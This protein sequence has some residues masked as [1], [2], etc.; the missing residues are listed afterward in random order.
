MKYLP[1]FQSKRSRNKKSVLIYNYVIDGN[2][3][4]F[5]KT[6]EGRISKV[7]VKLK[8]KS[9]LLNDI[10]SG[11]EPVKFEVKTLFSKTVINTLIGN[12]K[13]IY[14]YCLQ[15]AKDIEEFCNNIK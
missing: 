2:P 5:E 10:H 15:I 12:S 3:F 6:K 13:F 4:K 14:D 7:F 8:Y 1:I 9:V 11:R